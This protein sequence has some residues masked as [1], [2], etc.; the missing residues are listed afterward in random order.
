[1]SSQSRDRGYLCPEPFGKEL[2][3]ICTPDELSAWCSDA[4]SDGKSYL[5]LQP[6][7]S[8]IQDGIDI[9]NGDAMKSSIQSLS[10]IK[11][12]QT[13]RNAKEIVAA[14]TNIRIIPAFKSDI[15]EFR[16][17]T[18]ILNR[19]F[20]AWQSMTFADRSLRKGWQY[21]TAAGTG[22]L[23]LRYDPNYYYKGRG[24]I[25]MDACGPLDV[26][27]LGM[28]R[29]HDLQKAYA[30]AHRVDTPLHEAWR[31][32]PEYY[33]RIAPHRTSAFGRGTVISQAV[34]FATAALKRWGQGSKVENEPATWDMVDVYY[35]YID[36]E[37]VNDTG[38]PIEMRGPDGQPGTSWCYT[39][40]YLGQRIQIGMQNGSPVYRDTAR[41]DCLLYPNRRLLIYVEGVV[42]NPDPQHQA[43]PY[44]H[45]KV[46]IVQL[47]AD[48]WAWN[49]LGFPVTRY[50]QSLEKGSVEM[51]RG[52]VD[53][54]NG[55]LSPSRAYDRNNTSAGLA[56]A[57][58]T[59]IPNQYVG[60]DLGLLGDAALPKPL[61]PFQWYEYPPHYLQAQDQLKAM[62]KEQMGVS[63]TT[64]LARARQLPSGDSQ[65]KLLESLGPLIK[66]QSRNLEKSVC[67]IGEMWKSNFFQFITA[68]RRLSIQGFEGL[69]DEDFDYD[70]GTLIP[71]SQA[72]VEASQTRKWKSD[73][74]YGDTSAAL[75]MRLQGDTWSSAA[76]SGAVVPLFERARWHKDNFPFSVT[77]YSLHEMNS[78][79]RKLVYLQRK[80]AG[81]PM[82]PWTEAEIFDDRNFGD[83]PPSY[84]DPE[85]GEI[86]VPRT[87]FERWLVWQKLQVGIAKALQKEAGGAGAPGGQRPGAGRPGTAQ[88]PATLE[89][90]SNGSSVMRESKHSQ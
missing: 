24:D 19:G 32:F 64:A 67:A 54:M 3:S 82:D 78:M 34:K 27:P 40:P 15:P 21:A 20:M 7:Y 14:Q 2:T 9:V 51:W 57:L 62:I 29:Q 23:Y 46:P 43:S 79:T 83:P 50:G 37:S 55:R 52:M 86:R 17:Q 63:D 22:Y 47:V 53:A 80:K 85:T 88:Q 8:Y 61:L 11:T 12:D 70:P 10:S 1:M 6:A 58:N 76:A 73:G 41:T 28:G 68:A 36:D 45:A 44:W 31:M 87:G 60:L 26:L 69:A 18:Q 38:H 89:Q 42:V 72:L 66:D 39:V 84:E 71:A 33:D 49:F 81:F 65:E 13:V 4:I 48:D 75:E 77:P 74:Q 16:H 90:K 59:R 25:V 35:I 30:V 56:A 5:R